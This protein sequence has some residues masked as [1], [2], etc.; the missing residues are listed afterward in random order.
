MYI[1]NMHLE[2]ES[3]HKIT[4]FIMLNICKFKASKCTE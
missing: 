4:Q 1:K 2:Y 3:Q